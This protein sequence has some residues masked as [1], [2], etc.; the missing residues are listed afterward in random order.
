MI[1]APDQLFA[2]GLAALILLISLIL[3]VQALEP[4]RRFLSV[5]LERLQ[6]F[7]FVYVP[8]GVLGILVVFV[9]NLR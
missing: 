1:P 9:R 4:V 8:I 6:I 7:T 2:G 5:L 3:L